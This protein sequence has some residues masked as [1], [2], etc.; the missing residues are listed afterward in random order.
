MRTSLVLPALILA[1]AFHAA[2]AAAAP[3]YPWCTR[4]SSTGG[5]CAFNTFQQCLETLSGIGGVCIDN[6]SYHAPDSARAQATP[7]TPQRHAPRW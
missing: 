5:E 7:R 4:Y 2:P 6:P 1:G 3:V